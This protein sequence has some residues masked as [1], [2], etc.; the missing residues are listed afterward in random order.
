MSTK[1]LTP[2]QMKTILQIADT[3]LKNGQVLF[4]DLQKMLGENKIEF[5]NLCKVRAGLTDGSGY[6]ANIQNGNSIVPIM[7]VVQRFRFSGL[8]FDPDGLKNFVNKDFFQS[9]TWLNSDKRR[10]GFVFSPICAKTNGEWK[11]EF[12]VD[13]E[14]NLNELGKAY[15]CLLLRVDLKDFF[16]HMFPPP[17]LGRFISRKWE[18]GTYA[19]LHQDFLEPLFKDPEDFQ[20]SYCVGY[21]YLHFRIGPRILGYGPGQLGTA[22]KQFKFTL[23][24]SGDLDIETSTAMMPRSEKIMNLWDLDPVYG[25]VDLLN[26]LTFGKLKIREKLH[27]RIDSSLLALHCQVHESMIRGTVAE[28]ERRKRVAQ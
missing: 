18:I 1:K 5:F 17:V 23:R 25:S 9:S 28:W 2:S 12:D 8:G 21:A 27:D 15:D 7:G 3:A 11:Q 20:V 6:W 4:R 13:A 14:I 10:G 19:A 22:V 16:I 24:K 26:T